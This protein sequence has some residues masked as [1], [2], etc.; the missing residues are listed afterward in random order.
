MITMSNIDN[1]TAALMSLLETAQ[2]LPTSV[3][4][5]SG[6]IVTFDD[7]GSPVPQ[8]LTDVLSDQAADARAAMGLAAVALPITLE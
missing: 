2:A 5:E 4:G 3:T 8:D 7:N 6:Q 1:N